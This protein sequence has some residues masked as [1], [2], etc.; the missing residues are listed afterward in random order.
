MLYSRI[1]SYRRSTINKNN[2]LEIRLIIITQITATITTIINKEISK[3]LTTEEVLN[4]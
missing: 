1:C 4:N 2:K 3:Q